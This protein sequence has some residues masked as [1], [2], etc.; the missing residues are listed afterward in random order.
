MSE[1][2]GP[3]IQVYAPNIVNICVDEHRDGDILGRMYHCYSK[4][5]WKFPNALRLLKE[6]DHFYDDIS[7]PQ[8]STEGRL[9]N[10]N[11]RYQGQK[12]EP[13]IGQDEVVAH[14]GDVATFLVHVSYRQNS[15]WQGEVMWVERDTTKSFQSAL[16]LLKLIDNAM[17]V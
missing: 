10:E 9:F 11:A 4:D 15:S 14:R 12:K 6:M 17:D 13:V 7:F 16:E 3:H 1:K 5:Y 2:R 8:S